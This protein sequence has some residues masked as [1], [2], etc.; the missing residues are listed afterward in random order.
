MILCKP[1]DSKRKRAIKTI[2]VDIEEYPQR[3]RYDFKS[4]RDMVKFIKRVETIIRSSQEYKEY[5]KFLKN[6][7]DMNRC[8]IL[9]NIVSGD[10]KRYSIEIHHEPFSLF[11]IV[12]VVLC[13]NQMAEKDIN[14]YDIANEVM[15]LH[16]SGKVGLI[17]LTATQ[18]GMVTDGRIFIPLQMIYQDYHKFFEEYEEFIPEKVQNLLQ[19][20]VDMSLRCDKVQSND[21]DTEFVYINVDNFDLPEVPEEWG[22]RKELLENAIENP[23]LTEEETPVFQVGDD[24]EV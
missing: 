9:K 16:Y 8:A 19:F 15:E 17:P 12:Q 7:M 14:P 4:E 24:L 13:K 22:K 10:G 6:N 1:S 11:S 23:L 5:I 2:N 20:K 3:P 18:H 21:L